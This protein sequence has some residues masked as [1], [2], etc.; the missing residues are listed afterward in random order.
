MKI[1]LKNTPILIEKKAIL[2]EIP[3]QKEINVAVKAPVPGKGIAT[4]KVNPIKLL[5]LHEEYCFLNF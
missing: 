1:A 3:M 5:K 2:K 4:K